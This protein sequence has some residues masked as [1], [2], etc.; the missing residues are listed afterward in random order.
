MIVVHLA[1]SYESIY[2]VYTITIDYEMSNVYSLHS[3]S[4]RNTYVALVM[5][6]AFYLKYLSIEN[7]NDG[8]IYYILM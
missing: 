4:T 8:I 5:R 7:I 2:I 1:W 6:L 3:S